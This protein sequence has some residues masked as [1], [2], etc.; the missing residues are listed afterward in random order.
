[1]LGGYTWAS[2]LDTSGKT[3]HLNVYLLM[4]ATRTIPLPGGGQAKVMMESE[5]PW[6]GRTE[7]K[8]EAPEGWKWTVSVPKPD[9]AAD[10]KVS[11][12]GG[13]CG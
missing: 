11:C 5:M 13:P 12:G 4:S 10:V 9:Y 3:I 1:M 6:K 8:F 2:R 7:M